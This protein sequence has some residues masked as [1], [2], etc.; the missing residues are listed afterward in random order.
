MKKLTKEDIKKY[1]TKGEIKLLELHH[2]GVDYVSDENDADGPFSDANVLGMD[3][4]II[5][6]YLSEMTDKI[7][8]VQ[9][10]GVNTW[11]LTFDLL[12]NVYESGLL[13]KK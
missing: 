5:H 8:K 3:N 13:Q 7:I 9:D 10:K 6:H 2:D 11:Q 4:D 12:Y 1:G